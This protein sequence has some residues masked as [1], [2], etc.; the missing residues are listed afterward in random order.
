LTEEA[1]FDWNDLTEQEKLYIS[2]QAVQGIHLTPQMVKNIS[3]DIVFNPIQ[4]LQDTV[5]QALNISLIDPEGR[6]FTPLKIRNPIFDGV[7]MKPPN[8]D[9]EKLA[10]SQYFKLSVNRPKGFLSLSTHGDRPHVHEDLR[11]DEVENYA[12]TFL[13]K[14]LQERQKD[15]GA[16]RPWRKNTIPKRLQFS[17]KFRR[18]L[19]ALDKHLR[20]IRREE[21]K[22]NRIRSYYDRIY[23]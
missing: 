15:R 3:T 14:Y 23:G 13:V 19:Q 20:E 18:K 5:W 11:P 9:F 21:R 8:L 7:G 12:A 1:S 10:E 2:K 17:K 22:K 16:G 6:T 4:N